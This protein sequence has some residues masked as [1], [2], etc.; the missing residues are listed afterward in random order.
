MRAPA[1]AAMFVLADRLGLSD[2][3]LAAPATATALASTALRDLN[4]WTG[5]AAANRARALALVQPLGLTRFDGHPT[6]GVLPLGGC[7]SWRPWNASSLA[8]VGRSRPSSR[9][10]LLSCASAVTARSGRSPATST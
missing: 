5:Q 2:E 10:R 7:P 1:A 8:R 6:S 4:P 3:R 9:P